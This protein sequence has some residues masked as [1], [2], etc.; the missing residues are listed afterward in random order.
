MVT[1]VLNSFRYP[2]TFSNSFCTESTLE[3]TLR[4]YITYYFAIL[5]Q[6]PSQLLV[7]FI[8]NFWPRASYFPTLN[9]LFDDF[10]T[11][12]GKRYEDDLRVIFNQR[13]NMYKV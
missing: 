1:K 8:E 9:P 10:V 11:N 2:I 7:E 13:P 5:R 6:L 4:I 3:D 12:F